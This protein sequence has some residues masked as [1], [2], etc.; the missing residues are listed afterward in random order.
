MPK[1]R[2]R[3]ILGL[4]VRD[5]VFMIFQSSEF[6]FYDRRRVVCLGTVGADSRYRATSPPDL[7]LHPEVSNLLAFFSFQFL[8]QIIL[9]V[10]GKKETAREERLKRKKS[11]EFEKDVEKKSFRLLLYDL[12]K[13]K[14]NQV[15]LRLRPRSNPRTALRLPFINS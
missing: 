13:R 5:P 15:L 2:K 10:W 12:I 9:S 7:E 11:K 14:G 8:S 4:N 6:R 3:E 1:I